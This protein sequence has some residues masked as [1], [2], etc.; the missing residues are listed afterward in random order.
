MNEE[1]RRHLS[2]RLPAYMIPAHIVRLK[3]LPKLPAGKVDRVRL[4]NSDWED[5]NGTGEA[6]SSDNDMLKKLNSIVSE[7]LKGG[8]NKPLEAASRL[9]DIGI[10]SLNFLRLVVSVEDTFGIEFDDDNLDLSR[11]ETVSSLMS[12]IEG[13]RRSFD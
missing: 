2:D 13:R 10:D 3:E 1:L 12:Y 4:I 9:Q 8:L 6:V 5:M 7:V 11:F